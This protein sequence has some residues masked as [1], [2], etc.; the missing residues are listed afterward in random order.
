[1]VSKG[2]PCWREHASGVALQ[3]LCKRARRPYHHRAYLRVVADVKVR[4]VRAVQLLR[5]EQDVVVRP[6]APLLR[7]CILL[8]RSPPACGSLT[9]CVKIVL[10]TVMTW[11]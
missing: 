5:A 11:S 6:R 2:A 7:P 1:M 10:S 3:A 9:S 8:Q 4:E